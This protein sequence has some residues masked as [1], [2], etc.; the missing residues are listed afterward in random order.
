MFL[1]QSQIEAGVTTLAPFM[2]DYQINGRVAGRV[3]NRDRDMCPHGAYPCLGDDRWVVVSVRDESDWQSLC[4]VMGEP[5]W[6]HDA[7]FATF[8]DRK[9]NED[10][11]DQLI[12]EWT[13][14]RSPEDA[15]TVLQKAGVPAA[16]VLTSGEGIVNDTQAKH[17]QVFVWLDHTEIGSMLYTT[18]SYRLSK[19]PAHIWKAAPCLGEDNEYVLGEVLGYSDAEIADLLVEGAITTEADLPGAAG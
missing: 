10:E 19:T 4:R 15:M 6:C 13:V 12:S 3:G 17:R 11:L 18:P 5:A 14:R 2:L 9:S 8:P 16:V 7:R 1:D